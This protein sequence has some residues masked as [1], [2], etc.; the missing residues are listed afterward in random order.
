MVALLGAC[1][2]VSLRPDVNQNYA[3][4][5]MIAS[6][7]PLASEAGLNILR[8]GG[9]AVDAAISAQMVLNLVEP[10]SSGIGGGAFLLHFDSKSGA[11]ETYDGREVAP[12][13]AHSRMFL[14]PNGEPKSFFDAVVGGKSVGVPGLVRMMEMVHKEHGKLPWAE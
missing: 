4:K 10:Q 14:N 2:T 9:S 11:V 8:N 7:H 5:H 12:Q 13:S 1:Q 6:A 3:K